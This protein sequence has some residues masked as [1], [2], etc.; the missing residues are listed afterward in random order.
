LSAPLYAAC[1]NGHKEIVSLLLQ[2]NGID[3]NKGVS[4]WFISN[5]KLIE[6]KMR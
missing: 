1:E 2:Q 6:E 5:S 4:I 3:I